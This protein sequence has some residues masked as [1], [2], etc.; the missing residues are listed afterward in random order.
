MIYLD[1]NATTVMPREV[2]QAMLDWCNKGNPSA[3]YATARESQ[4]M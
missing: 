4:A 3:G 2:K 1:N